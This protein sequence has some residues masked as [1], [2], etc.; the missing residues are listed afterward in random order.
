MLNSAT[1]RAHTPI[2]RKAVIDHNMAGGTIFSALDLV[3]GYYQLLV[4]ERDVPLTAVSTPGGMLW[5]WH[6]MP[7]GLGNALAT[8]NRMVT[9]LLRPFRAFV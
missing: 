1:I 6:V 9:K 4:R 3:D 2:P 5:E 7:Q 8:F